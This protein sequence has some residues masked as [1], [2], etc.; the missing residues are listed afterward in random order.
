[1]VLRVETVNTPDHCGAADALLV[2]IR[3]GN[4]SVTEDRTRHSALGT[5]QYERLV[6]FVGYRIQARPAVCRARNRFQA[7]RAEASRRTRSTRI[8]HVAMAAIRPQ[9][10]AMPS[11]TE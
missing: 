1:M 10:A 3:P 4:S 11:D 6:L 9:A 8:H 5:R 7:Q 2:V